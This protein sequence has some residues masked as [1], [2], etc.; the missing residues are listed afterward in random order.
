M[1]YADR[2]EVTVET[3]VAAPAGVVWELVTD[4][5]LPARFSTEFQGATWN[6]DWTGPALGA[7][8]TGRNHNE[9]MGHWEVPCT[10]VAFDPPTSFGWAVG[11]P[12]VPMA[13]WRFDLEPHGDATVLRQWARMGPG[14]SGLT[15]YI[16]AHLEKEERIVASRLESW[17]ANMQATVDGISDLAERH[18]GRT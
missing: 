6:D 7:T 8:F 16:E 13:T 15:P 2:P 14:P 3:T 4:I 11:D 18:T 10:V 5:E 1:R 12:E 9:G 17:R